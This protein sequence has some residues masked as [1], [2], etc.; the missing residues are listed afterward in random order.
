VLL[1]VPGEDL[2]LVDTP[3]PS[4]AAPASPDA[5]VQEALD[6]RPELRAAELRGQALVE[7][8]RSVA[9]AYWPQLDAGLLMQLGN[10]P[11]LAGSGSRSVS[12][13]AAIPFVNIVG[14]VQVGLTLRMN[15]FDTF[16]TAH[17]VDDVGHRQRRAALER[18]S[19]G[20]Q[21][22]LRSSSSIAPRMRV[23]Q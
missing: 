10:N 5:L 3:P 11:A 16:R 2:E 20:T 21:S 19:L 23:T 18:T 17:A 8:S 9:S 1:G 13:D 12:A 4:T 15:I 22:M 14:D 6:A 7:E